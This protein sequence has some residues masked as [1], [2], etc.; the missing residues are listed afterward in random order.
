MDF[1]K[2]GKIVIG[3]T[4]GI[5]SG[6]SAASDIFAAYGAEVICSDKLSAHYF[7][8]LKDKIEKHFKT[9]NRAEIAQRIFADTQQRKWLE[10]LLH[11]LITTEAKDI[12]AN[13]NKTV[14]VFDVPL[15]FES[16]FDNSFDFTLC[17]YADYIKRLKRALL[18]GF[19]ETDF[20][21][22]DNTQ[23]L[24]ESKAQ[25]A[26]IVLYNNATRKDLEEKILK[27]C[28]TLIRG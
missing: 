27:L 19:S 26:D 5:A 9:T 1:K 10:T 13:T 16:G 14:I 28:K 23:M 20:K 12:I 3:L 7:N 6:K 21:Q 25:R 22:R 15:L 11:P 24:L 18:K 8:V 4:G 2:E 17:I